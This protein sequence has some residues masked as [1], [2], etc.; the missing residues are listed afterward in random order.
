[1]ASCRQLRRYVLGFAIYRASHHDY[2]PSVLPPAPPQVPP[3]T[4]STQPAASIL[5][6]P[7]PGSHPRRT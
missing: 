2:Q 3:R 7:P 1:M 4:P 6:T 5:A